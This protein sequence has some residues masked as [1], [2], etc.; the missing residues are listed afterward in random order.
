MKTTTNTNDNI[1]WKLI[2]VTIADRPIKFKVH[3]EKV[4]QYRSLA[5]HIDYRWQSLGESHP[6]KD[7][8][9]LLAMIA[10]QYAAYMHLDGGIFYCGENDFDEEE[11]EPNVNDDIIPGGFEKSTLSILL[12]KSV[13]SETLLQLKNLAVEK[14]IPVVVVL[15]KSDADLRD[16]T[17]I[18]DVVSYM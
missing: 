10:L 2:E 3:P 7:T 12:T 1:E 13:T 8:Q 9:H 18:A 5:K 11:I 6:N 15:P 14:D 16:F 4:E 17:E